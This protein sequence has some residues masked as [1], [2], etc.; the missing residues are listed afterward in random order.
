MARD[1]INNKYGDSVKIP[2]SS[3]RYIFR[4]EKITM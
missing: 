3:I 4:N 1:Y 2:Y